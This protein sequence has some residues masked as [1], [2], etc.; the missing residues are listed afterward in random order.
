MV[1]NREMVITMIDI[2]LIEA[3]NVVLKKT[4]KYLNGDMKII[5]ERQIL[6]NIN[7]L[8]DLIDQWEIEHQVTNAYEEGGPN[9]Y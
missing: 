4:V 3:N 7:L 1:E 2:G 6:N 5:V 8:N 9:G